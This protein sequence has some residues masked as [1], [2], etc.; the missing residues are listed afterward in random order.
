MA[1]ES[2]DTLYANFRLHVVQYS[3][4]CC[5]NRLAPLPTAIA[6][7]VPAR[8]KPEDPGSL[9]H[10]IR[11]S[12]QKEKSKLK[13]TYGSEYM[14]ILEIK[15]NS[16]LQRAL[17]SVSKLGDRDHRPALHSWELTIHSI[18]PSPCLECQRPTAKAAHVDPP[19]RDEC[20]ARLATA[21][22]R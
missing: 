14:C 8:C 21:L 15:C 5:G 10:L 7:G 6:R 18:G 19:S 11:R 16:K 1:V 9:D 3:G 2:A 12:L 20:K 17:G 4:T 22:C 13:P